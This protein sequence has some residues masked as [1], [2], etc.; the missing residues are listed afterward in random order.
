MLP[1]DNSVKDLFSFFLWKVLKSYV[2]SD[3]TLSVY[4]VSLNYYQVKTNSAVN[5]NLAIINYVII[6][7]NNSSKYLWTNKVI[8]IFYMISELLIW[9]KIKTT[10]N[11]FKVCQKLFINFLFSPNDSPSKTMKNVFISSKNLFLLLRYSCFCIFVF[12]SFFPCQPLLYSFIQ[13]KSQNLW[14]HQLSK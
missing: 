6:N 2:F 11:S 12:L 1:Y 8:H 5:R 7:W 3:D 13:E 10:D 14:C 9:F 4:E